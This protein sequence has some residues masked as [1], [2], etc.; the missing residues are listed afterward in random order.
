MKIVRNQGFIDFSANNSD[1]YFLGRE[2][3]YHKIQLRIKGQFVI[4]GS[5]VSGTPVPYNPLTLIKRVELIANGKDTLVS[6]SAQDLYIEN[7]I[8]NQLYGERNGVTA[9][10]NQTT[11]VFAE[12][13][14]NFEDKTKRELK[15]LLLLDASKLKA[16]ELRLT[17]GN[18]SDM[19]IGDNGTITLNNFRVDIVSTE[20]DNLEFIEPSGIRK[21]ASKQ[22]PI[23]AG[24]NEIELFIGN[25]Y[26][27]VLVSTED[28]GALDSSI[29]NTIQ[30]VWNG[31][32]Y[33]VNAGFN[34][35]RNVMVK[36]FKL[37]FLDIGNG[38]LMI[39]FDK[40]DNYSGLIPTNLVDAQG[41]GRDISSF[42]I[43][44]NA[45]TPT[46]VAVFRI[47]SDEVIRQQ[48]IS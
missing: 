19:I 4:A 8:H 21:R 32:V 5:T 41:I 33:L 29:V 7:Y 35:L 27:A 10:G 42:K 44:F 17:F 18:D 40:D 12:C 30:V 9:G 28:N 11:D 47:M 38:L 26:N 14:I 13:E 3:L 45:N 25:D 1:S 43:I 6:A 23:A 15:N 39:L 34:Q 46:G 36:D 16:L 2:N 22:I 20:E 37:S 48:L 24:D 31:Q